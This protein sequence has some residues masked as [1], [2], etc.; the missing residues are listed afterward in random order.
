MTRARKLV[1]TVQK[2]LGPKCNVMV[3]N[4]E[5]HHYRLIYC[6]LNPQWKNWPSEDEIKP[7]IGHFRLDLVEFDE[8]EYPLKN[9]TPFLNVF[10]GQ[11][12]VVLN[13]YTVSTTHCVMCLVR[14]KK[15][16][17]KERDFLRKV[18]VA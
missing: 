10:S 1:Q 17:L 3:W 13:I 14:E 16:T 11:Y 6:V 7:L 9:R 18:S 4:Q 5:G 12:V 2:E 8:F 15:F